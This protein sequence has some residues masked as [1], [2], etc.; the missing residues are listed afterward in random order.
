MSHRSYNSHELSIGEHM[1]PG[2]LTRP[3]LAGV[4][5]IFPVFL[6]IW[7]CLALRGCQPSKLEPVK[8]V[9][10]PD[11]EIDPEVWGKAY[12]DE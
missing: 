5:V 2:R 3:P 10:L 6:L 9:T 11:G 7:S 8:T 4:V 1:S 12:P